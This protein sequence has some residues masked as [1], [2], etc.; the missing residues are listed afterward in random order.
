MTIFVT[1]PIIQQCLHSNKSGHFVIQNLKSYI[2]CLSLQES[3][4]KYKNR[5]SRKEDIDL[6]AHLK[7]V[8]EERERE[9]ACL[10][11]E[12]RFCQLELMNRE[13]TY[14]HLF[15]VQPIV[16]VL[17]PLQ[18]HRKK[19]LK[20]PRGQHQSQ[21][22][23]T[24]SRRGT[25]SS[26]PPLPSHT[27]TSQRKDF[28]VQKSKS[29]EPSMVH[30]NEPVHSKVAETKSVCNDKFHQVM[31]VVDYISSLVG[32]A[33]N[34]TAKTRG[35]QSADTESH[36]NLSAAPGEIVSFGSRES[37]KSETVKSGEVHPDPSPITNHSAVTHD[38]SLTFNAVDVPDS[39]MSILLESHKSADSSKI[40]DFAMRS[41]SV[42]TAA[43]KVHTTVMSSIS[44]PSLQ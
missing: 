24:W 35:S 44:T 34:S 22:S 17:D 4:Q 28:L 29:L 15:G 33:K 16:G 37:P 6:I 25:A 7:Q 32:T 20:D 23:E 5:E 2:L 14:N 1:N 8:L 41:K 12:K 31:S 30:I 10:T 13:A 39:K 9:N 42:D 21:S 11:E 40:S 43:N 26:V 27:T 18:H 19:G 3:E 36:C 38:C